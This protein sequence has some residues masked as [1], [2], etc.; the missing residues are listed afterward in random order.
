MTG[1]SLGRIAGLLRSRLFVDGE[2]CL[3][4]ACER[5]KRTGYIDGYHGRER[6]RECDGAGFVPTELGEKILELMRN[7]LQPMIEDIQ[8]ERGL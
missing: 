2:I 5:C 3:Q 7:N 1:E 8:R 4:V 6:C